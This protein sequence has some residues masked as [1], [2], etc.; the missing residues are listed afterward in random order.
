MTDPD[1]QPA[2]EPVADEDPEE[3]LPR[4]HGRLRPVSEIMLE[5][6]DKHIPGFAKKMKEKDAL[7]KRKGRPRA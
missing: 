1:I 7:E 3:T 6:M 2:A 5:V 4:K